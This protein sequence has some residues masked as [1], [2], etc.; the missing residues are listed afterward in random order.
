MEVRLDEIN[1]YNVG[2]YLQ[3]KMVEMMYLGQL[4]NVNSF[5]QPNVENYKVET[6]S[7]LEQ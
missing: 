5:N 4:L 2:S 6:R 7:L 3:F 1:E